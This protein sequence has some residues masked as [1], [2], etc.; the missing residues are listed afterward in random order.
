[1]HKKLA[2]DFLRD[3]SA[4][5][6][7][8]R[9]SVRLLA[10]TSVIKMINHLCVRRNPGGSVCAVYTNHQQPPRILFSR[11]IKNSIQRYPSPE[12][13]GNHFL[14]FFFRSPPP[15]LLLSLST[16]GAHFLE[17]RNLYSS[18]EKRSV[19]TV[20]SEADSFKCTL[21]FWNTERVGDRMEDQ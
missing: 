20:L 11:E 1:M 14:L 18:G 16:S 21:R 7:A 8:A 3:T 5:L 15:S 17:V 9:Q 19:F 4:A 13:Q 10:E 2:P 12:S 6:A